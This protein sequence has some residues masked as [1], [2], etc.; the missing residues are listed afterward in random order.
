MFRS[1]GLAMT[2]VEFSRLVGGVVCSVCLTRICDCP[3]N[4]ASE[5]REG[6]R[7]RKDIIK[8]FEAFKR[9]APRYRYTIQVR[10]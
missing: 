7:V 5:R 3:T 8:D 2:G 6:R 9:I 4:A 10:V 1:D